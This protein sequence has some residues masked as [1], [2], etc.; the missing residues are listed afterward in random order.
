MRPPFY[1]AFA[2]HSVKPPT[3]TRDDIVDTGISLRAI[4][5]LENQE[6]R[7]TL[8]RYQGNATVMDTRVVCV[9][10]NI[11]VL[12]FKRYGGFRYLTGNL[13]FPLDL[14]AYL[15]HNTRIK[16][17]ELPE[18]IYE[19]AANEN[20]NCTLPWNSNTMPV[21][22]ARLLAI[23]R[24]AWHPGFLIPE[25]FDDADIYLK[26]HLMLGSY[27]GKNYLFINAT[28]SNPMGSYGIAPNTFNLSRNEG[29]KEWQHLYSGTTPGIDYRV[30]MSLCFSALS[31]IATTVDIIGPNHRAEP[32]TWSE[33]G[34]TRFESI[35]KQLVRTGNLTLQDRNVL[36]LKPTNWT[37]GDDYH[38][39]LTDEWRDVVESSTTMDINGQG[40]SK[41][42]SL[43]IRKAPHD[44]AA[45]VIDESMSMITDEILKKG[46]SVAYV[47]QALHTMIATMAYYEQLPHFNVNATAYLSF[48]KT[49]QIPGGNGLRSKEPAGWKPGYTAVLV[50]VMIHIIVVLITT[51]LFF[52]SELSY[53]Y[54]L[55]FWY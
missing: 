40:G 42:M 33:A 4:L 16:F 10:P 28:E 43:W 31:S 41:D 37:G 32:V 34:P 1:P 39:N 7:T 8:M 23:C 51:I 13:S 47:L 14:R 2:E 53:Y 20:F 6:D 15:E 12:D 54:Q 21:R 50:V 26:R 55:C 44:S 22:G 11:I 17:R 30:S 46:H 18:S 19:W 36:V 45:L 27:I 29:E 48:L 24:L 38:R 49:V 25:F 5:P 3:T 52:T 9:R 35:T